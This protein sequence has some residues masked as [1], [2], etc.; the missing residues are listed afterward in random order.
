MNEVG[1]I[2]PIGSTGEILVRNWGIFHSYFG[3]PK[4]TA[5][6]KDKTGWY[7]TG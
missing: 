4:L 3:E 6:V 1:K 5:A 2:V 7:H